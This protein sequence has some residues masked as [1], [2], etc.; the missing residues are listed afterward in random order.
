[1]TYALKLTGKDYLTT[2]KIRQRLKDI[3]RIREQMNSF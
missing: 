3:A 1:L 2:A